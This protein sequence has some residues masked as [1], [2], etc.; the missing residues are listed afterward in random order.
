M[1]LVDER[2]FFKL[3]AILAWVPKC[4]KELL[5]GERMVARDLW[6]LAHLCCSQSIC[7][8]GFAGWCNAR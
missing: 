7:S 6:K 5:S 2:D 8:K 3:H 1:E 4:V